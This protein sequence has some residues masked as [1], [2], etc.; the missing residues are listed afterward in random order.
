M[1]EELA[2]ATAAEAA[3]RAE[4][5]A[6]HAA[7]V[8]AKDEELAAKDEELAAERHSTFLPAGSIEAVEV[9]K[10][11]Y[12]GHFFPVAIVRAGKKYRF[13]FPEADEESVRALFATLR[14][15]PDSGS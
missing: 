4:M 8:A 10:A 13:H 1:K 9:K 3:K 6:E 2:Q 7:A 12:L 11:S 15:A 5:E 14:G